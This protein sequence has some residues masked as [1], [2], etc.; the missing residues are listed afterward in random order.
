MS[1]KQVVILIIILYISKHG[2]HQYW[3]GWYAYDLINENSLKARRLYTLK[4]ILNAW[5][6]ITPYL[7][8]S[9]NISMTQG[10]FKKGLLIMVTIVKLEL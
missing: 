9:T 4:C 10:N 3:N 6:L 7:H 5:Y 2:L 1:I 8:L